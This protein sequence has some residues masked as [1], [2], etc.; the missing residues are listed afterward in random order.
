MYASPTTVN[1]AFTPSNRRVVARATCAIVWW[2][3]AWPDARRR[4]ASMASASRGGSGGAC[5]D[6]RAPVHM[7]LVVNGASGAARRATK[8]VRSAKQFAGVAKDNSARAPRAVARRGALGRALFFGRCLR[9]QP[10]LVLRR[11]VRSVLMVCSINHLAR[12]FERVSQL[13]D[14]FAKS[15]CRCGHRPKCAELESK[16]TQ[17]A[18]STSR[19]TRH[20]TALGPPRPLGAVCVS[21]ARGRVRPRGSLPE[22][23]PLSCALIPGNAGRIG[24]RQSAHGWPAAGRARAGRTKTRHPGISL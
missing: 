15:E 3:C 6:A 18:G 14:A 5:V 13:F 21:A 17:N 4:V 12:C 20:M 22:F 24:K 7:S 19:F 9:A 16:R 23:K 1:G 2:R 10:K 11:A 8:F